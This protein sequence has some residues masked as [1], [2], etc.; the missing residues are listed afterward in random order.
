MKKLILTTGDSGAG[1]LKKAGLAD[2]VIGF[3]LRFVWGKL[4]SPAKLETFLSSRSTPD[5]DPEAYW[6]APLSGQATEDARGRG[7]GLVEFCGQFETVELWI[8]P[9]PNAQLMLVWLLDFLRPYKHVVSRFFLV[10]PDINI[11]EC[12]PEVLMAVRPTLAPITG[13]HL[14]A[15]SAA[16]QAWRAPTPELWAGLLMRDL[17]VLPRL[18]QSVVELLE[19][20]PHRANGLGA[21]ELRML[22]LLSAQG[23]AGPF[24][25]FPGYQ[26]SNRR[27]VFAYWEVGALL[28]GLASG[29]APAITGLAEGPF[30]LDMHEDSGRHMRYTQSSLSLTAFGKAAL[31][32]T[33]DFSR[34]NPIHRWWG[35]TEL[36]NDRL[37]RWDPT[38]RALIAP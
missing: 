10:Q 21:T 7:L 30:T 4:W 6:L 37:W 9:E 27:R 36:T 19:E 38:N 23:H 13:D 5:D 32:G 8:D 29:P 22:E 2:C 31:A 12:T 35:G 28:D 14:E 33:D 11:S 15:A 16:W 18:S 17:S 1:A 24:D 25:L 34:H 26:K 3:G 20:L